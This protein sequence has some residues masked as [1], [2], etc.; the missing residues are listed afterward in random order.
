M[1]QMRVSSDTTT[2]QLELKTSLLLCCDMDICTGYRICCCPLKSSFAFRQ[3]LTVFLFYPPFFFNAVFPVAHSLT[4]VV[5]PPPPP[6][7]SPHSSS[8]FFLFFLSFF[9][10]GCGLPHEIFR[11]QAWRLGPCCLHEAFG[12]IEASVPQAE[13]PH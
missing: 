5:P 10:A 2:K 9:L 13:V 7:T 6:P 8:L 3:H 11:D 1:L 12:D 4:L